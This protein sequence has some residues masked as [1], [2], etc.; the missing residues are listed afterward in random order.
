MWSSISL[1]PVSSRG[2]GGPWWG[3][4]CGGCPDP[5]EDREEEVY[6][7]GELCHRDVSGNECSH[8]YIHT[9]T[10]LMSLPQCFS[11]FTEIMLVC[12]MTLSSRKTE[13]SQINNITVLTWL[14][15]WAENKL[16]CSSLPGKANKPQMMVGVFKMVF[17]IET[18]SPAMSVLLLCNKEKNAILDVEACKLV[19]SL[20]VSLASYTT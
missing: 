19:A 13:F 8:V 5:G 12:L 15:A 14:Q 20:E 9:H 4:A 3:E 1:R 18:I 17:L 10:Y 6:Y 2:L 7:L 11:V 16:L